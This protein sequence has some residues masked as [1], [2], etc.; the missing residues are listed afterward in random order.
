MINTNVIISFL[1]NV[2]FDTGASLE[3]KEKAHALTLDLVTDRITITIGA[4]NCLISKKDYTEI[5]ELR[6]E[7]MIQAIKKLRDITC[8]GLQ[9]AKEAVE[10]E[11]WG[12]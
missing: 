1:K 4:F 5:S 8:C 6:K 11:Q 9:E 7:R 2:M 3:L 12:S 10:K